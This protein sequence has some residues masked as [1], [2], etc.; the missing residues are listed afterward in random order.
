MPLAPQERIY[1]LLTVK[2]QNDPEFSRLTIIER[3][4]MRAD[5]EALMV[6]HAAEKVAEALAP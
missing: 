4:E 2:Y 3:E 1:Q 6:E 5:I